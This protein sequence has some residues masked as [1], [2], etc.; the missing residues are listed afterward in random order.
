M[1]PKGY[2]VKLTHMELQ[3]G[4]NLLSDT[5]KHVFQLP[6]FHGPRPVLELRFLG[7]RVEARKGSR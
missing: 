7:C 4:E 3:L 5:G 2:L 6:V 1:V